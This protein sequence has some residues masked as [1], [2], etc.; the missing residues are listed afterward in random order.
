MQLSYYLAKWGDKKV[1]E[2]DDTCRSLNRVKMPY[3]ESL[4]F[5]ERGDYYT[6][7]SINERDSYEWKK[8]QDIIYRGVWNIYYRKRN[9]V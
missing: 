3:E 9:G 4:D 5:W 7:N 2:W 6:G 1:P 8:N